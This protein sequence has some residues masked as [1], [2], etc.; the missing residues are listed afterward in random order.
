MSKWKS[1]GELY[2]GEVDHLQF[3]K[4][5]L[6]EKGT[7]DELIFLEIEFVEAPSVHDPK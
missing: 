5:H 1:L 7:E 6:C 3:Y 2:D 4:C